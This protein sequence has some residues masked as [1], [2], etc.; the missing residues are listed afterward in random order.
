[1]IVALLI[2]Q[3]VAVYWMIISIQAQSIPGTIAAVLTNLFVAFLW[4]GLFMVNPNESKVMQLFGKYV[5][6]VKEP[7]L[8][9]ANPLY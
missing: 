9:W 4:A 2:A 8:R 5:G 7:G 1:M 6:T 3:G